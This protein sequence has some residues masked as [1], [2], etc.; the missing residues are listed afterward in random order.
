MSYYYY[1]EGNWNSCIFL[2]SCIQNL[3]AQWAIG[4]GGSGN[5]EFKKTSRKLDADRLVANCPAP[6]WQCF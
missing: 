1:Y 2:N 3:M 6:V 5:F 4:E